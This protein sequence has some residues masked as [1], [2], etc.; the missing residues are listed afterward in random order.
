MN[1]RVAIVNNGAK[2]PQKILDL[3]A[4]ESQVFDYS[5]A[6]NINLE[7]FDLLILS[8]GSQFFI[9]NSKEK[10]QD[11]IK[12]IRR[13]TILTLG[14]C[15]GCELIA[16]AFGGTL[17]D[18][19]DHTEERKPITIKAL[20]PHPLFQDKKEFLAF[21]AHRW[22]IDTMPPEFVVLAE[23]VHGP[24]IIKHNSLPLYGFQFHPEIRPEETYGDELFKILLQL[25]KKK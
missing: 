22:I 14:I 6:A 10:L 8:G 17:K 16:V 2:I 15:Y 20:Q 21:D 5:E 11:E 13:S 25:H 4:G 23:S 7:N 9:E 19:G 12:L 3:V 18:R 24:E 1:M